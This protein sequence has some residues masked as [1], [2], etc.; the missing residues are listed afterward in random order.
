MGQNVLDDFLAAPPQAVAEM[1]RTIIPEKHHQSLAK[2]VLI[3]CYAAKKNF[4]D[5]LKELGSAPKLDELKSTTGISLEDAGYAV[6]LM[7]ALHA[8]NMRPM[9]VGWDEYVTAAP[10]RPAEDKPVRIPPERGDKKNWGEVSDLAAIA[11]TKLVKDPRGYP[12]VRENYREKHKHVYCVD[13]QGRVQY[14]YAGWSDKPKQ[15]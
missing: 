4:K 15:T 5:K 14:A 12:L 9:V 2:V 7:A 3:Q 11:G 13:D 8:T 6:R 10:Y 1:L